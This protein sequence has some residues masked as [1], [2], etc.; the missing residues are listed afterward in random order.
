MLST[1]SW[2]VSAVLEIVYA[3]ACLVV[4]ASPAGCYGRSVGRRRNMHKVWGMTPD[5]VNLDRQPDTASATTTRQAGALPTPGFRMSPRSLVGVSSPLL[6]INAPVRHRWRLTECSSARQSARCPQPPDPT[7]GGGFRPTRRCGLRLWAGADRRL[8]DRL[9]PL[10]LRFLSQADALTGIV[11]G[12]GDAHD[13]R[14]VGIARDR[15]E[16]RPRVGHEVGYTDP[17]EDVLLLTA[18]ALLRN[19]RGGGTAC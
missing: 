13:R 16:R 2:V 12:A 15:L 7:A 6:R 3:T 10:G 8:R 17:G 19:R 11:P 14:D 1:T 9:W 5:K 18:R 4:V